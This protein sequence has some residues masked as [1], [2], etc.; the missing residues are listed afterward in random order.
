MTRKSQAKALPELHFPWVVLLV[1]A[2]WHL[3]TGSVTVA[4][5]PLG[6]LSL[7]Y[8]LSAC[9]SAR[10]AYTLKEPS[11]SACS[12]CGAL[13][14]RAYAEKFAWHGSEPSKRLAQS[15]ELQLA[16]EELGAYFRARAGGNPLLRELHSGLF[17]EDLRTLGLHSDSLEAWAT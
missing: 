2:T 12:T 8:R 13:Q 11:A 6:S 4:L 15:E 1:G 17:L 5:Q 9:C 16:E 14:S 10:C 3:T 7:V